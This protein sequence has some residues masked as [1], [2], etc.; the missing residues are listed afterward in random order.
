MNKLFLSFFL[1]I[2]GLHS[3]GNSYVTESDSLKNKSSS[4][5]FYWGMNIP[6]YGMFV[7]ET[8]RPAFNKEYNSSFHFVNDFKTWKGMDKQFHGYF[9]YA[10]T[11]LQYK[12]LLKRG[13]SKKQSQ[14]YS[15]AVS[16]TYAFTK[17]LTDAHVGVGGFSTYDLSVGLLGS[18]AYL[19]QE[20]KFGEDILQ[21]KYGF[22]PSPYRSYRTD[23]LGSNKSQFYR[24]Y[25]GMTVWYSLPIALLTSKE[26]VWLDV[27]GLS[28]GYGANGLFGAYNN[29]VVNQE[30]PE[31]LIERY[32]QSYVGLDIRF[33]KI[34]TKNK[35]LRTAF[36]LMDFIHLPLPSIEYSKGRV[37]GHLITK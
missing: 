14:I 28:Y 20:E 15:L 7:S 33:S 5:L 2:I 13:Y 36:Y 23:L 1:L 6:V 9:S 26:Q 8:V 10:L 31:N 27:L 4:K 24:D 3:L 17:E 18:I 21:V 34:P 22:Y 12:S 29:T 11:R 30:V 37:K 35:F 19:F 32:H 16:M 25:N